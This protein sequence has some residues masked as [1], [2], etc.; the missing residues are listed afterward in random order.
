MTKISNK[1]RKKADRALAREDLNIYGKQAILTA[2][3]KNDSAKLHD[4]LRN[5]IRKGI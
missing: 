3:K 5:S 1:L 2:I 4:L